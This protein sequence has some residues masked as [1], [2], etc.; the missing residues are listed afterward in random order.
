MTQ[1]LVRELSADAKTRP[2]V[3]GATMPSLVNCLIVEDDQNDAELSLEAIGNVGG[4][5]ALLARTGDEAMQL[6]QEAE[7]EF[8]PKFDI[9]FVDLKLAGSEAQ[10]VDVIKKIQRQFPRTHT[11][12][13]SGTMSTDVLNQLQG[14]YFGIVSKPLQRDNLDEILNK[15]RMRT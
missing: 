14:S 12:I 10:G 11:I 3:R 1:N 13:V 7:G 9:V 5:V 15:H 2:S 6:L 8:R 4:V